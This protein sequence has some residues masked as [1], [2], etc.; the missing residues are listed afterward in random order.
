MAAM[1]LID[2]SCHL[3]QA[4]A[5][6]ETAFRE[7]KAERL[8]SLAVGGD[9]SITLPILR[10]L[11]ES[12]K[13][14]TLIRVDAHCDTGEEAFGNRSHQDAPFSR[15]FDQELTDPKHTVQAGIRNTI[16]ERDSWQYGYDAGVHVMPE[17]PM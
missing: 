2:H 14:P 3:E 9:R 8:Q 7:W 10:A 13:P 5:D 1:S 6:I 4:H 15:D 16:G 12:V 11:A 17:R